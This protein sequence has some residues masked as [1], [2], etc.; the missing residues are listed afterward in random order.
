MSESTGWRIVTLSAII[1]IGALILA[2]VWYQHLDRENWLREELRH[3]KSE[4]GFQIRAQFDSRLRP[5]NP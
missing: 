2:S 5:A 4:L 1:M 3:M